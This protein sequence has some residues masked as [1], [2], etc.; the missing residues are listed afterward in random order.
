ML[1]V[2]VLAAGAFGVYPWVR[3]SSEAGE[4]RRMEAQV[5]E[6]LEGL[7]YEG[8]GHRG[9]I[10][11]D[12]QVDTEFLRRYRKRHLEIVAMRGRLERRAREFISGTKHHPLF[13]IANEAWIDK[14]RHYRGGYY[15]MLRTRSARPDFITMG[16]SLKD[17]VERWASNVA[18]TYQRCLVQKLP[19]PEPAAGSREEKGWLGKKLDKIKKLTPRVAQNIDEAWTKVRRKWS[20]G[21]IQMG[22]REF[23]AGIG[24]DLQ[25]CLDGCGSWGSNYQ[26][27]YCICYKRIFDKYGC[28]FADNPDAVDADAELSACMQEEC[29]GCEL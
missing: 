26:D 20:S 9:H 8:R 28:D 6:E 7:E 14:V 23:K 16:T 17:K 15:S 18:R 2:L 1:L 11:C 29:E 5:V 12:P 25:A 19:R 27:A 4:L 24:G 21:A 3:I 10:A 13:T 22:A